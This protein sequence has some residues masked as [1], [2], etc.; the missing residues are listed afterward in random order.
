M[1]N[2]EPRARSASRSPSKHHV[3]L[4]VTENEAGLE[5]K[6]K[7][8]SGEGGDRTEEVD[9]GVKRVKIE[10]GS[11]SSHHDESEIEAAVDEVNSAD[12][13]S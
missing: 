11:N 4:P 6:R 8:E 10:T 3:D 13:G 9:P 12:V 2:A 5:K 7:V 1:N